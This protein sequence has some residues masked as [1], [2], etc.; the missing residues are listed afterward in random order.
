MPL[1]G[2][3]RDTPLKEKANTI[4]QIMS[5]RN[6]PLSDY[7]ETRGARLPGL[8]RELFLPISR[9]AREGTPPLSN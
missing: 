6:N 7:P 3:L 2:S 8:R 5:E 9:R 4:I 1:D